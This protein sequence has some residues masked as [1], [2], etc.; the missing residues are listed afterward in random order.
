MLDLLSVPR[1]HMPFTSE[2]SQKVNVLCVSHVDASAPLAEGRLTG[3]GCS[4]ASANFPAFTIVG[5]ICSGTFDG[6]RQKLLRES[7]LG[8]GT[9]P[10]ITRYTM[11]PSAHRSIA[12]VYSEVSVSRSGT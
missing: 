10:V 12:L 7:K 9:A 5:G 11:H 3:E 2:L 8:N 6:S 1:S 4:N